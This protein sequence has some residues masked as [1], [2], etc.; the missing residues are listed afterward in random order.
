MKKQILKLSVL[1]NRGI[2]DIGDVLPGDYVYNSFDSHPM[3]VEKVRLLPLGSI[4]R[5]NY[6]DKRIMLY[7]DSQSIIYDTYYYK[8][9]MVNINYTSPDLLMTRANI[10]SHI[11]QHRIDLSND[12][13]NIFNLDVIDEYVI[14]PLLMYG[15][16]NDIYVNIPKIMFNNIDEEYID[17]ACKYIAGIRISNDKV[18]FRKLYHATKLCWS[19]LLNS[20]I[21]TDIKR[22]NHIT[23]ILSSYL[24]TNISTRNR[25]VKGIIR[26]GTYKID[27]YSKN[28]I[29]YGG[30]NFSLTQILRN[31]MISL[32][33]NAEY[34]FIRNNNLNLLSIKFGDF[35]EFNYYCKN[36]YYCYTPYRNYKYFTSIK[37]I[38]KVPF[39]QQYSYHL[40]LHGNNKFGCFLTSNLI[41]II[42]I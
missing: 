41:P 21:Y 9:N 23:D 2:L 12:S 15:D 40:Q 33:I 17:S 31:I 18:Y 4:Y 36:G 7:H 3:L 42:S 39:L 26:M 29:I 20:A 14:G 13:N 32:G 24:Y 6:S 16:I 22:E 19:D 37:S 38:I 25:L 35:E 10:S 27:E 34:T 1:T 5:V 8:N 11:G 30:S 28:V